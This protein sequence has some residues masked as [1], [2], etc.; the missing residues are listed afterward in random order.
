MEAECPTVR[1]ATPQI[2]NWGGVLIQAAGG[3]ETRAGWNGVDANY[4]IAMDWNVKDGRFIT[5]EEVRTHQKFVCSEMRL[6]PLCSVIDSPLG[7]EIKI[8]RDSEY[9]NRWGQKEGRRYT[10]TLHGYWNI[11]AERHK[12]PVRC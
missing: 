8:A 6:R 7:Q 2:W 5:D 9:H 4:N 12:S 11:R 1:A 10:G 3:T